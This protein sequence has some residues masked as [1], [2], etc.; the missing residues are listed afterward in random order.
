MHFSSST[1]VKCVSGKSKKE[2]MNALL[3]FSMNSYVFPIASPKSAAAHDCVSHLRLSRIRRLLHVFSS[4][5]SCIPEILGKWT[6]L[7]PPRF[8]LDCSRL[9]LRKHHTTALRKDTVWIKHQTDLKASSV[10]FQK[11]FNLD[12]HW[13]IVVV[14]LC[15]L[16]PWKSLQ[17]CRKLADGDNLFI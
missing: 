17:S 16:F 7:Q 10:I 5:A 13:R 2:C 12:V 9:L 15:S 6:G 11:T 1:L 4:L 8:I 14:R 3:G